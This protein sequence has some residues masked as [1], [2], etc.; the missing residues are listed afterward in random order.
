MPVNR[1]CLQCGNAY[2]TKPSVNKKFCNMECYNAFRQAY[3]KGDVA[4]TN[5]SHSCSHCGKAFQ[6]TKRGQR[7]C[8]LECWHSARK[9]RIVKTCPRCKREFEVTNSRRNQVHCSHAC[10]RG[11]KV[12]PSQRPRFLVVGR[13]A[14]CNRE[15]QIRPSRVEKSKSGRT[16]CSRKCSAQYNATRLPHN[17]QCLYC[18]KRFHRPP[19]E[20]ARGLNAYCCRECYDKARQEGIAQTRGP[21]KKRGRYVRCVQ[22]GKEVYKP[23]AQLKAVENHFCSRECKKQFRITG[24]HVPRERLLQKHTTCQLCGL[25]EPNILVVHH[26]D[27]N[28]LNNADSNLLV[29]CPNCHAR[30]HQA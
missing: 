15:I 9:N 2:Q 12:G 30:I 18:G 23:P 7:F 1:I 17:A 8:S 16:F 5:L 10:R 3:R 28:R 11:E 4:Q 20:L 13:C 14:H 25:N 19:S 29:L 22:C 27:G 21:G 24:T 26:K 6:P